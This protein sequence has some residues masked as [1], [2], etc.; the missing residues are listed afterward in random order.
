L[1][2]TDDGSTPQLEAAYV[3]GRQSYV[4]VGLTGNRHWSIIDY[5]EM[6]FQSVS[7]EQYG[8]STSDPATARDNL[9]AGL[10][11]SSYLGGFLYKTI[12]R[13]DYGDLPDASIG[14][15]YATQETD[16]GARHRTDG[17]VFLGTALDDEDDGQPTALASG[18]DGAVDDEDGVTFVTDLVPGE[19]AVIRVTAGT[20]GYLSAFIDFDGD[21]TLGEVTL[22][23][24][25]SGG[26]GTPPSPGTIG[27]MLLDAPDTYT[28]TI[29]V[30]SSATIDDTYS[31]FRFT[32]EA[33]H[34]GN[35]PTGGA[36]SGEVEDH[37]I[38]ASGSPTAVTIKALSAT[39]NR[40]PRLPLGVAVSALLAGVAKLARLCR[41]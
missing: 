9:R 33:N 37:L 38:E 27:D 23:S 32:E 26:S 25:T 17:S 1:T 14:G 30:P 10:S 16:D 5:N 3:S 36:I 34:G 15:A 28:M 29:S 21:G 40:A 31:R 12:G 7:W 20:A 41:Q 24:A 4:S 18:D 19:N 2:I 8:S 11:N 35:S 13:C 6:A 22:V 39:G